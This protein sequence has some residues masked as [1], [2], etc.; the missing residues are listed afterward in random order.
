[1]IITYSQGLLLAV[2]NKH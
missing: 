2:L 1:M